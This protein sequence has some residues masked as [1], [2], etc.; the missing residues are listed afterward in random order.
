M[1]AAVYDQAQDEPLGHTENE[2]AKWCGRLAECVYDLV[3][4][5]TTLDA[6]LARTVGAAA[7]TEYVEAMLR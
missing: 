5:K 2:Y 6:H 3:N 7:L 4:A 1:A